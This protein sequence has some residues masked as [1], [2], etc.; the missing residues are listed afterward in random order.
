[1]VRFKLQPMRG[2]LD[3]LRLSIEHDMQEW[4]AVTTKADELAGETAASDLGAIPSPPALP[5]SDTSVV[6]QPATR[7]WCDVGAG[8][9]VPGRITDPSVLV[10]NVGLGVLVELGLDEAKAVAVAKRA[11]LAEKLADVK[12][13]IQAVDKDLVSA[14]GALEALTKAMQGPSKAS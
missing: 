6:P 3:S 1:M 12:A 2:R 7:T 8:Y 4:D 11:V 13:R 14:M 9:R 5:L 10:V